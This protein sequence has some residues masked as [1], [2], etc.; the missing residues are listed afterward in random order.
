MKEFSGLWWEPEKEDKQFHG[1][2]KFEENNINLFLE[3]YNSSQEIR[4]DREKYDILL[5]RFID[6][7]DVT[8]FNCDKIGFKSS[9]I[10]GT[11]KKIL[12][13]RV[14]IGKHFSRKDLLKFNEVN[15]HFDLLDE[16][17]GLSG[18]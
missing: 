10:G 5:G 1:V 18:F 12:V 2:L 11:I 6:G 17:I 9:I 4:F 3:D 7:K 15:V 14:I 16:W 8:L 13:E